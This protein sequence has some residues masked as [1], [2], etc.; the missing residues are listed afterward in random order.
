MTRC[1]RITDLTTNNSTSIDRFGFNSKNSI[2]I[3][4]GMP[5]EVALVCFPTSSLKKHIFY[6]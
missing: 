4:E 1:Q 6:N 2:S 5:S 3:D